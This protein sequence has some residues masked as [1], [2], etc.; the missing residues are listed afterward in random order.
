M[1]LINELEC[2]NIKAVMAE[3]DVQSIPGPARKSAAYEAFMEAC[4]RMVDAAATTD[5]AGG[6]FGKLKKEAAEL[7]PYEKRAGNAKLILCAY[8]LDRPTFDTLNLNR[9]MN[10][11]AVREVANHI[12]QAG[13]N[14]AFDWEGKIER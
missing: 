12:I 8:M 9:H 1:T 7:G 14:I 13:K 6:H 4:E 2:R 5:M 3:I 10:E 11:D